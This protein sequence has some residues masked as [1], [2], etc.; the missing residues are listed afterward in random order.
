[1]PILI[2]AVAI[3][4]IGFIVGYRFGWNAACELYRDRD[5]ERAERRYEQ[6]RK[7]LWRRE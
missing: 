4:V 1:M 7:H 3:L 5:V 2:A 6:D